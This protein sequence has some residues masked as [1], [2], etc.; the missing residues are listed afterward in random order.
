MNL[1]ASKNE[2]KRK[3]EQKKK[4]IKVIEE[5]TDFDMTI[6]SAAMG[7]KSISLKM[8]NG[9]SYYKTQVNFR[10]SDHAPLY[11]FP[12]LFNNDGTPWYEGNQFLLYSS[13]NGG[14]EYTP[15]KIARKASSLLDYKIWCEENYLDMFNFSARRPKNRPTYKYFSYLLGLGISGGNLNTRT[16]LIYDFSVFYSKKY[17]IDKDRI[18]QV[19]DMFI[20]Y[21]GQVGQVVNKAV[22][23]RKQTKSRSRSKVPDRKSVLDDGEYLRPLNDHQQ[24]LLITALKGGNFRVDEQ[25]IFQLA[26]DSGARKQTIL[27]LR[28]KHLNLCT[29]DNLKRDGTYEIDA[30]PGCLADSKMDKPITIQIPYQ[31]AEKLKTYASCKVAK[32]RRKLFYKKFGQVFDDEDNMYI[33]LGARGDCRYMSKSDPRYIKTK[34]PPIGGSIQTIVNRLFKLIKDKAFPSGFRFHWTRASFAFNYYNFLQ[35][36]VDSKK[37]TYSDQIAFIQNALC[38]ESPLTTE[39][40]LKIFTG[41]DELAEMQDAWEDNFFSLSI[42]DYDN[43]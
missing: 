37:I 11:H 34:T 25:L 41:E 21:K 17:E 12:N 14:F 43:H 4:R 7:K 39:H 19:T 42:F 32:D 22:K 38:H 26:I 8:N 24:K 9:N 3:K 18:D 28:L 6:S 31:L 20:Q 35:P 30:G 1:A 29:P 16:K 10:P 23:K 2:N 13:I 5:L 27:T 40:Y 36:L 15:S 33:F